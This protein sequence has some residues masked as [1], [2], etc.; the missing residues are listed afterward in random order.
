MNVDF[1]CI[2]I[3]ICFLKYKLLFMKDTSLMQRHNIQNI[4]SLTDI[5]V[6]DNFN[7]RTSSYKKY[8]P[9]TMY[10]EKTGFLGAR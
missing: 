4:Y 7:S 8:H 9:L 5:I 6:A 10:F 1:M 3:K 2:S